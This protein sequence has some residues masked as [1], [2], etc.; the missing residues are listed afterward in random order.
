MTPAKTILLYNHATGTGHHE[1]W[2]ALFAAL[3]LERGY[4][5][6]CIT[7]NTAALAVVLET[8]GI[9]TN[10]NLHLLE[11]PTIVPPP[12][13]FR[14]QLKT[15][16]GCLVRGLCRTGD[17][18]VGTTGGAG[19]A[20][21]WRPTLR[22]RWRLNAHRYAKN[23]SEVQV[24]DDL[25]VVVRLKR[26]FLHLFVPPVWYALEALRL[27]VHRL[28]RPTIHGGE[29]CPSNLV[30]AA[31]LALNQARWKPDYILS[32]YADIWL[33]N[34]RFWRKSI[35]IPLPWGGIRFVP[36]PADSAAREGC[37]RD[38]NF[39][40]LCFLDEGA[41]ENYKRRDSRRTYQFLPDVANISLPPSQ[42][43]IARELS[44]LANGRKIVLLCGS[45]ESRKNVQAFCKMALMPSANHYF[46]AIVGQLHP[47]TFSAAESKLLKLFSESSNKNTLLR[48]H[49]F[50][51]EKDMN[52]VIQVADIIFAVYK[53]FG[54]SS[55]MLGKAAGFKKPI[56]V[57]ENYLMGKRVF[58]YGIGTSTPED[59]AL[60]ILENLEL[61]N[62][63]GVPEENFYKF[64]LDFSKNLL[65]D[66]LH[67]FIQKSL[68]GV[69]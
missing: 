20:I 45:I 56:L 42:P 11:M 18:S 44:L 21:E 63:S 39:R 47:A 58:Q 12:P 50:E 33:T 13:T 41:I 27:V 55:N 8:Q 16:W 4:R 62:K 32:M 60:K 51:D 68:N 53:N 43:V 48:N 40:G 59:D 64:S 66:S 65:G 24:T 37:F 2:T 36:F 10:D 6:I 25:P 14:Q 26:H 17:G 38:G 29:R 34:P 19:V 52:A 61:L 35:S 30:T 5:V 31:N 54:I 1:S 15:Q 3:L 69:R 57:S 67:Y 49:Y 28:R 9:C 23:E 22:D 46:F 7:P